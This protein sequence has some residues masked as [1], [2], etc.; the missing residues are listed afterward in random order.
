MK[1]DNEDEEFLVEVFY[2]TKTI[3]NSGNGL[4]KTT[5]LRA[6]GICVAAASIMYKVGKGEFEPA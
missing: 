5:G 3:N 2:I 4:Q 1:V 6:H